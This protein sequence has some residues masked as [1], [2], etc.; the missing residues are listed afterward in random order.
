MSINTGKIDS[1]QPSFSGRS[2]CQICPK[3]KLG[4]WCQC[5]FSWS[6]IV[7]KVKSTTSNLFK[8]DFFFSPSNYW[9]LVLR[10]SVLVS[11]WI[12]ANIFHGSSVSL[13][14]SEP[15]SMVMQSSKFYSIF[16]LFQPR[17]LRVQLRQEPMH[18]RVLT[19]PHSRAH[20]HT[21]THIYTV[22]G[23]KAFLCLTINPSYPG[24][25]YWNMFFILSTTDPRG[26][27]LFEEEEGEKRAEEREVKEEE[28]KER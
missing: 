16:C 10:C 2:N 6:W 23:R 14:E 18:V 24:L 27:G 28:G 3:R 12:P 19:D 7:W 9:F 22:Y 25:S 1:A 17:D 11:L 21:G 20:V 13:V 26:G 15:S 5:S 4:V 8:Q